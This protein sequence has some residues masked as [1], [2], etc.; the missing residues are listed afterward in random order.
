MEYAALYKEGSKQLKNAGITEAELDARL[1]L[2]EVC[3]TDRNDLLV[4]GNAE[5]QE[6]KESSTD[7]CSAKDAGISLFSIFWATRSL[8]GCVFRSMKMC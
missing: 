6:E 4:H 3:G 8:W 7:R 1:M 2:Q 5:V